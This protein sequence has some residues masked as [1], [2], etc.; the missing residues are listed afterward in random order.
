MA[1]HWKVLIALGLGVL[2][3]VLI[4][5]FWSLDTWKSLGVG[6]AKAFV[7]FKESAANAD[8]GVVAQTARFAGKANKFAGDFFLQCLKFIGV[9]V[10]LFSLIVA[11]AD[12]GDLR[13]F[14]RLGAKTVAWFMGTTIFAAVLALA[15]AHF[16]APGTYV[17]AETRDALLATYQDVAAARVQSAN[18]FREG[19]VWA[20]LLSIVPTNPFNAIANAQM[21]QVV[22]AS[23]LLGMGLAL[24]PREKAEPV[25]AFARGLNEALIALVRL[26]MSFAPIAVFC[27]IC[28]MVAMTGVG[29]LM[30]V[31]AFGVCVIVGLGVIL[32]IEYPLL[33]LVTSRP[34]NRVGLRRFFR[35]MAPA[36]TLAFA[37]SSS[38]ATLPVTIQCVRDRLGVPHEI[39]NFVCPL[40]TTINMDGTALYQVLSV[41]FLSQLYGVD[42]SLSQYAT[43]SLLAVIVSIGS[44]GL[45][46]ASVVMMAIVLDAVGV[47]TQG[48][49]IIL[50]IDRVLDMAR[51]I[52]NVS[53]DAVTAVLVANGEGTLAREED[54]LEK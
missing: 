30:S 26:I 33:M 2:V 23:L 17:S 31:V 51:T 6:D 52:V 39:A 1:L 42:L 34:G 48:V 46:G 18:D 11:V 27:L 25:I 37:S 19:G 7:A 47:P 16:A 40:G 54:V 29:A 32:F 13:R 5:H 4:N 22:A 20:Y 21:I 8:A 12:V 36:Q 14:G 49:A 35:G 38:S 15:I 28:H 45:P 53:G 10:I 44:P 43:V 3:G 24:I 9:P 41:L 50:A